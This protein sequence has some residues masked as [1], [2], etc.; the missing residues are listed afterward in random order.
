MQSSFHIRRSQDIISHVLQ[1]L[2]TNDSSHVKTMKNYSVLLWTPNLTYCYLSIS[3]SHRSFMVVLSKW[4]INILSSLT[5]FFQ[6]AISSW[7][8]KRRNKFRSTFLIHC[9]FWDWTR[10]NN[11]THTTKTSKTECR[12]RRTN[13]ALIHSTSWF[14]GVDYFAS[15]AEMCIISIIK[16]KVP[17][18]P[19]NK[20]HQKSHWFFQYELPIQSLGMS[21]SKLPT[22]LS[23]LGGTPFISDF[24]TH[25]SSASCVILRVSSAGPSPFVSSTSSSLFG[26]HHSLEIPPFI[27]TRHHQHLCHCWDNIRPKSYSSEKVPSF[28]FD[29]QGVIWLQHAYQLMLCC[30]RSEGQSH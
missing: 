2:P 20:C 22:I 8:W 29:L 28:N 21:S 4:S 19:V 24:P 13:M 9:K 25:F 30:E 14:R 15:G 10:V 11:R 17:L 3:Y 1:Q 5:V 6:I 16:S 27:Q 12:R 7:Y 26:F 18:P 23:P